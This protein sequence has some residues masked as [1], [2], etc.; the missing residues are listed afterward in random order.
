M[1]KKL[2]LNDRMKVSE[3]MGVKGTRVIARIPGTNKIL[4]ELENK[5][6]AAGSAYVASEHFDF[7]ENIPPYPVTPSYNK[8]LNLENS[9]PEG[10]TP[11]NSR[12]IYL[13]CIGTD[14]CGE[15]S[16]QQYEVDY[17]K[18]LKPADMIPF[19]YTA[20]DLNLDERAKYF[21]KAQEVDSNGALTGYSLYYFKA[22]ETDPL[23]IQTRID[24]SP[25]SPSMYDDD[26]TKTPVQSYVQLKLMVTPEDA[27]EWFKAKDIRNGY[28]N[29]ISLLQGWYTEIGGHRYYQDIHPVTKL[30]FPTEY[31]IDPT[32]GLDITYDIF[33]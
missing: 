15:T 2:I 11:S 19:R 7:G 12:K 5:V 20:S 33:Y 30:N 27:R 3:N 17:T 31:L 9:S 10:T 21:G 6:L 18:W 14:G 1:D 26:I 22:F 29:T 24:G 16:A 23:W 25:L 32:K 8:A 4:W 28:I 13:F